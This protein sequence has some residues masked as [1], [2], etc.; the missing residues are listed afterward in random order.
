VKINIDKS[1]ANITAIEAYNEECG[2]T[3]EVR[4]CKYW[5]NI[6]EQDHR[7]VKEKTRA[8]LGFKAFYSAHA[9]LQ[10]PR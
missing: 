9:T 5:N 8:A 7:P 4:Q 6:V 3:I 2:S 10:G 1:G